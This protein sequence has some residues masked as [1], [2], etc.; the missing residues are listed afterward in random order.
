MKKGYVFLQRGGGHHQYW[1]ELVIDTLSSWAGFVKGKGIK[2]MGLEYHPE[3]RNYL[4]G[5]H[6]ALCADYLEAE[7]IRYLRC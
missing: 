3:L 2:G 5:W 4:K 6:F 1:H 7:A